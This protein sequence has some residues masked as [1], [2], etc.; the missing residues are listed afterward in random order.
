[1]PP[2]IPLRV[3]KL[4]GSLLELND[5]RHRFHAWLEKQVPARNLIVVGGGR[6]V[7]AIRE[8]DAIHR[9]PSKVTHWLCVDV[10]S[11]TARLASELLGLQQTI[12]TA[13]ELREFLVNSFEIPAIACIQPTAYYTPSIARKE[14]CSLPESWDCTSDSI[15]A[16]LASSVAAGELV[17]L[18][19]IETEFAQT[20]ALSRDAIRVL[21][22]RNAV[23]RAFPNASQHMSSVRIINL[24]K[25]A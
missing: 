2:P 19:S 15:S 16:W 10:M 1:M 20:S 13:D 21:A 9:L 5:L 23:D 11:V 12:S 17:L 25:V 8:L 4:G 24:R 6:A 18:K 3:I 7:E 22:D 14:N